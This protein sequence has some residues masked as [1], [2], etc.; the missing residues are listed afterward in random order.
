MADGEPIGRSPLC[1]DMVDATEVAGRR[2]GPKVPVVAAFDLTG[3]RAPSWPGLAACQL[4]SSPS[5][6]SQLPY[7]FVTGRVRTLWNVVRRSSQRKE[8]PDHRIPDQKFGRD[9]PASGGESKNAKARLATIL[10]GWR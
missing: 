2:V 7:G 5:E 9:P 3:I 10:P 6:R 8:G 1:W 4:A